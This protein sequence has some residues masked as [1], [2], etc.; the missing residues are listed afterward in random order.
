MATFS[1]PQHG[2]LLTEAY[3]NISIR[4]FVSQLVLLAHLTISIFI[5]SC[6][7]GQRITKE[8]MTI[9]T[10]TAFVL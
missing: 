1:A 9:Y 6:F 10:P 4:Q 3:L 8:R 5:Y 7:T 2:I